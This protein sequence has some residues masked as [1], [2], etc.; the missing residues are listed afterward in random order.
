M[1]ETL[2]VDDKYK[3]L[4]TAPPP[5]DEKGPVYT[6]D[7]MSKEQGTLYFRKSESEGPEIFCRRFDTRD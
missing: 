4:Y 1:G 3:Q 2:K 6:A 7:D 5:K